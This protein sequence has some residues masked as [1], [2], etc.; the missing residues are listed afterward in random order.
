MP[1]FCQQSQIIHLPSF[2]LPV[3]SSGKALILPFRRHDSSHP[4]VP[5]SGWDLLFHLYR[6]NPE[7]WVPLR[8]FRRNVMQDAVRCRS[9]KPCLG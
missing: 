1:S 6:P 4:R 8:C 7:N 3:C 2:C 9:S 5:G